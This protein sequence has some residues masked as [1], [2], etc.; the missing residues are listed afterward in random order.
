[1]PTSGLRERK[2]AAT[3]QS[4]ADAALALA[5]ERGPG[6][7]TV[8]DIADAAEVSTRT[9]FNYFP[10]KEAAILGFDPRRGEDVVVALRERPPHEPPLEAIHA[11]LHAAMGASPTDETAAEW[12]ARARLVSEH[13]HLLAAYLAGF[14]TLEAQLAAVVAERLDLDPEADTYPRLVVTVA[15]AAT[16]LAIHQAIEA[17]TPS[18]IPQGVDQAFAALAA[19]LPPPADRADR[20]PRSA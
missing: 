6:A 17:S 3:R 11:A 16:R 14:A 2:K 20:P 4:I 13:P 12:S 5:L 1:M 7:V 10:S 19:G 9:V 8:D 18:T 15:M